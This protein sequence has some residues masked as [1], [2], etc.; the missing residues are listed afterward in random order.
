MDDA[1]IFNLIIVVLIVGVVIFT[2]KLCI[3]VVPQSEVYVV[4]RF[5]KYSRTL[6]AGLSLIIPY[7]DRVAHR[8]SVLERQLDEQPISVITKDNVEVTLETLTQPF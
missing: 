8:V 1:A 3:N 5:G 4:E 2:F 6:S 7:L